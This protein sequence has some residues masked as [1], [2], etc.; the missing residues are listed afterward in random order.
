MTRLNLA[1]LLNLVPSSNLEHLTADLLICRSPEE[2]AMT[3]C[4][5][6]LSFPLSLTNRKIGNF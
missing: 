2:K 6:R 3:D 1:L 4:G 5:F